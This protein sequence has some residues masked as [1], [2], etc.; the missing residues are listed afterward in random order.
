MEKIKVFELKILVSEDGFIDT[1]VVSAFENDEEIVYL[2]DTFTRKITK[3][4]KE[5]LKQIN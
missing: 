5:E 1:E 2:M 4:I 3:Q